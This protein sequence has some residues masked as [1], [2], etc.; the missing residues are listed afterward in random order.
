MSASET[1]PLAVGSTLWIFDANR[2]VYPKEKL[3]PGKLWSSGPPIWREH[4]MPKVI[5]GETRVSWILGH[6]QGRKISKRDLAAGK[7]RGVLTSERDLDAACY[8]NEHAHAVADRVSRLSGG[9][10][11]AEVLRQI[12]ALV[13]PK[14]PRNWGKKW[15]ENERK[16]TFLA[17]SVTAGLR[18]VTPGM[19]RWPSSLAAT[20][21]GAEP[22]P[23]RPG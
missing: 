10:Q 17:P 8:V 2:R 21:P 3:P 22:P 11:A 18:N 1:P 12:A 16:R 9:E 7:V 5:V 15:A 13:I 6:D 23:G 19:L 20:E 4:W 14:M